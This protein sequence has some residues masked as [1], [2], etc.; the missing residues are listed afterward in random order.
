MLLQ[1]FRVT[2]STAR[3]NVDNHDL[4]SSHAKLLPQ[5]QTSDVRRIPYAIISPLDFCQHCLL[6]RLRRYAAI[7]AIYLCVAILIAVTVA[8]LLFF[9]YRLH[10]LSRRFIVDCYKCKFKSRLIHISNTTD[11]NQR[12]K[13][14]PFRWNAHEKTPNAVPNLSRRPDGLREARFCHLC[15]NSTIYRVGVAVIRL[16]GV[17]VGNLFFGVEVSC[18]FQVIA[19]APTLGNYHKRNCTVIQLSD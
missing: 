16:T 9:I 6:S 14:H 7:S 3:R 18:Q 15:P 5:R 13:A 19:R 4:A 8:R 11:P 17:F 10:I 2:A 1:E 12:S